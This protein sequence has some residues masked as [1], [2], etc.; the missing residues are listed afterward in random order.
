M[1]LKNIMIRCSVGRAGLN[2]AYDVKTSQELLNNYLLGQIVLFIPLLRVDGKCGKKTISLIE[3]FQSAYVG[4]SKPDG[5]I[6]VL[7]KTIRA[8]KRYSNPR[9]Q[10]STFTHALAASKLVTAKKADTRKHITVPVA[11]SKTDPRKLKTRADIA[12]IYGAISSDKRWSKKSEFLKAYVIP[13]K[14]SNDKT[15]SWVNIY[16]PK[17][18]KVTKIW[19]HK[20]MHAFLDKA[21]NNL[22]SNN[23]LSDLK[24]FGGCHNIRSTR[25]SNRWSAHSWGLAID[26]NVKD[27]G[28]GKTPKMSKE[29]VKCFTDAGFG[30]GGNYNRKDGMHFTLAGFD[31]PKSQ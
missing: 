19:C 4:M 29:F 30:W 7:G 13:S 23:L 21:L 8:L 28:L 10:N 9:I 14:I 3:I 24:E 22:Q 31:M 6:D 11:T 18:R 25:G 15:Y 2:K 26:I 20:A 17:K 5:R 1:D 16:D 27:N 12:T